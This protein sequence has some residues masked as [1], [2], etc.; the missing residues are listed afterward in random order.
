MVVA[1]HPPS[2]R[3]LRPQRPRVTRSRLSIRNPARA[4]VAPACPRGDRLEWPETRNPAL[5]VMV[6][7]NPSVRVGGFVRGKRWQF[8]HACTVRPPA[9][10]N[11][12]TFESPALAPP[13]SFFYDGCPLS[14][15]ESHLGGKQAWADLA[16]LVNSPHLRSRLSKSLS[17]A[18]STVVSSRQRGQTAVPDGYQ[19]QNSCRRPHTHGPAGLPLAP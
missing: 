3:F 8:W 12:A 2:P 14:I 16:Q 17:C 13:P 5:L 19:F 4:K 18:S 6:P 7:A 15:G 1:S 9:F 10:P 11:Q